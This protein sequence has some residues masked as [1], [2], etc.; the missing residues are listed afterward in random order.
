MDQPPSKR[1]RESDGA[2]NTPV[3]IVHIKGLKYSDIHMFS[4]DKDPSKKLEKLKEIRNL[5]LGQPPGSSHRMK[6]SCDLIPEVICDNHGFHW[7][8][9]KRF[10]MNLDRLQPIAGTSQPTPDSSGR[11]RRKPSTDHIIFNPDCIFCNSEGRKRIKTRGIWTSQGMSQFEFDGWKSVLQMAEKKQD[12]KLLTRIRGHDLFACEAKFHKN[13]RMNYMQNADKWRSTD[14]EARQEQLDLEEAHQI[15]FKFVCDLIENDVLHEHKVL[16][17]SDLR[18]KYVAILDENHCSNPDYRSHKLKQKLDRHEPFQ[19]KLSFCEMGKFQSSILFSTAITVETAIRHAF[20]LGSIDMVE[21][22]GKS[23]HKSIAEGFSQS[24]MQKWPPMPSDLP[25]PSLILPDLLQQLLCYVI[26][27]RKSPATARQQRLIQSIGQD[28]CRASTNGSWKLPKHILMS[29]SLRHL[30]RSE[31]LITFLNRMGHC[32]SYSFSLELET[33]LAAALIES[34]SQLSDQIIRSPVGPSLFH[35]EFDNFDCLLNDLTG[36]GSVHTAHGIMLQEVQG[37]ENPTTV[38]EVASQTRNRQRSLQLTENPALPDCYVTKRQSP[39]LSIKALECPTALK[40]K[41]LSNDKQTVWIFSRQMME[42]NQQIPAWVGFISTT[43][44]PPTRLTTIDYYPVINQ[45]ITEYKTVQECLR[46]A[47]EATGEVGQEYVITT[48]DLGVCMKAYPL[49]WNSPEKYKK[50]IILI[51]T[52]HLLCAYMK[53]VGKKMAGSGLAEVFL[54]AGMIGSGSLTGVMSGKHYERALHCHTVMLEC[55]ERLLLDQFVKHQGADDLKS[56]MSNEVVEKLS[57]LGIHLD[58]EALETVSTDPALQELMKKFSAFRQETTKGQLGKTAQL[59]LSYM[60]HIRLILRLLEAVKTNNIPLYADSV[61]HMAPLFFSFDG[62]NYARYLTYFSVFLANLDTSHPGAMTLIERGAISVAR[63]Y[64][65]GCRCDVDKTMEETFMRHAKSHGGPGASGVGV[66]GLLTNYEAYQRW[67]RTTHARSLYVDS[68]LNVAGM[69]NSTDT[70]KHRTLRITEIKKGEAIVQRARDAICNFINP[71]DVDTK[72]HLLNISSGCAASKEVTKDVLNA[73]NLGQEARDKFIESR[74][75]HG[76]DFFEPVKRLRLKSLS[77]MNKV[78]KVTTSKNKVMQFKQQGNVA[79]HL[80]VRSQNQ[81]LQ[82]DLKELMTFP[83]TPVPYSLATPDGYFAKTDKSKGFQFLTKECANANVPSVNE[84]LTVLDGNACF[85]YLKE[86]PSNFSQICAKIFTMLGNNGDVVFSTD[87]YFPD[88]VKSMERRRRGC[89][90][91]LVLK[92]EATKKPADWKSFLANDENKIQLI[93]LLLK[94]W[95]SHQYAPKLQGRQ[96]I[97]ICEEKAFLITSTD[98]KKTT[99][100]EIPSLCSTQEETDSRI[101]L[102][103]NYARDKEYKFVR[104]KSPDSDIFFILLHYVGSSSETVILFDTGTGNKQR[105]INV[106]QLAGDLGQDMCTSLMALHAYSGCDSTSA[107]RGIGKVK[108]VKC[109]LRLQE[110]VPTLSSLGDSWDV[111]D[112]VIEQL[113]SFTCALYGRAARVSRVDDL[114]LIRISETC[115][116]ENCDIPSTNVDM[117][118]LPP[119]KQ[120]LIQHIHRVNHQVGIWKRAHIPNPDTPKAFDG[121]GWKMEDGLLQPIWYA[122]LMLP[123]ALADIALDTIDTT[124]EEDSDSDTDEFINI[125]PEFDP[126]YSEESDNE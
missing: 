64:V 121:H 18:E 35:S 3:C 22:V 98:G 59:W 82:L 21:N 104:V 96:L 101:I 81:G 17:L 16:R 105:L 66:S 53:A 23:V 26:T 77:D 106:S 8:C 120:S 117:G 85:H 44:L 48:F 27:G 84:T 74:L 30:F 97:F 70:T 1:K 37:D 38:P 78:T 72:E 7:E 80:L 49:V 46:A 69:G 63:S 109:L 60:E 89:G 68:A 110:Y 12:E 51:G 57:S 50:H 13:C 29:M 15:A 125:E 19:G 62:Q 122:G 31:K 58:K 41:E 93:R 92:G 61:R 83:L 124:A 67:V 20:Q 42:N 4:D 95:S 73:E 25:D 9:Y 5:R 52:F 102:Y 36:K 100:V 103:L 65:P 34:S 55:L 86:V 107:F 112:D 32:E 33:A 75:K 111:P 113:E 123:Q 88:S 54:E 71:F 87:Q 45:P 11:M 76:V 2:S 24:P 39:K 115:T 94:V 114:R 43:G 116:K 47:E 90:E 126:L 6:E 56:L 99:K 28:V 108:P 10:T 118:S 91:K 79:F 40:A 14:T 119:C